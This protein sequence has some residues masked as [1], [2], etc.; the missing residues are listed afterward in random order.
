MTGR[1][2]TRGRRPPTSLMHGQERSAST[3]DMMQALSEA[4][5]PIYN[6]HKEGD[7]PRFPPLLSALGEFFPRPPPMAHTPITGAMLHEFWR[8][9]A[10]DGSP[11]LDPFRRCKRSRLSSVSFKRTF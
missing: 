11:G 2:A 7:A 4:W 9:M 1:P 10:A 3:S 6:K 8:H 5:L